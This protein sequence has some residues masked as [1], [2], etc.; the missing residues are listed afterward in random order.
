M[1][2]YYSGSSAADTYRGTADYDYIDSRDGNDN[3]SGSNGDDTLIRGSG[4]DT[5]CGG[6]GSDELTGGSGS[7]YFFYNYLA[8]GGDIITD[9]NP[10]EDRLDISNFLYSEGHYSGR[11]PIADGYLQLVSGS[12]DGVNYTTVQ[13]DIDGPSGDGGFQTL[14]TL[15]GVDAT[16]LTY[17]RGGTTGLV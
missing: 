8:E 12:S 16:D 14:A 1:T 9:F 13:I 2:Q 7:D 11:D 4:N 15:I 6:F 3:L 17:T 5:L 10:A